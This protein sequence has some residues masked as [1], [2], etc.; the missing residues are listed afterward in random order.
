MVDVKLCIVQLDGTSEYRRITISPLNSSTDFLSMV[1]EKLNSLYPELN[2]AG[3]QVLFDFQYE[4]DLRG[5][6]AVQ[7]ADEIN[8]AARYRS[9]RQQMLRLFV[10]LSKNSSQT[11]GF[12]SSKHLGVICDGCS[13]S[14][15][16]GVRYKCLQCYDYDL[17]ESCH[18]YKMVHQNH[19]FAKIR[20]VEQSDVVRKICSSLIHNESPFNQ[21]ERR[22][23]RT[24][25]SWTQ[26]N[27]DEFEKKT[28]LLDEDLEII[29]SIEIHEDFVQVDSFGEEQSL[30]STE[31]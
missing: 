11:T 1:K 24:E 26:T 22:V 5:L 31:H 27:N 7:S 12:N 3:E 18:D 20:F 29:P 15:I 30:N 4:D 14:P 28:N 6:V 13:R 19:V 23:E 21:R 9:S 16:I 10:K 8:Q 17:C 25:N 2:S